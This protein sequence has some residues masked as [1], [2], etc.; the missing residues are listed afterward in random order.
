M[1]KD[2]CLVTL[3][4]IRDRMV[5]INNS[6]SLA[7]IRESSKRFLKLSVANVFSE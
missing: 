3:L 5:L 7:L 6:E 1:Q 4:V 2:N